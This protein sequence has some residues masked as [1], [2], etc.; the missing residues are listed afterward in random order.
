LTVCSVE[1]E[2]FSVVINTEETKITAF[3]GTEPI[4]SMICINNEMQKKL[5]LVIIC[6]I[7]HPMKEEIM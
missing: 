6:D 4:R 2:Q 7:I 1:Y 5:I 3:R